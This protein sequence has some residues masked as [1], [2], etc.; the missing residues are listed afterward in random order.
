MARP[1]RLLIEDRPITVSPVLATALGINE[2]IILQQLHFLLTITEESKNR[3]N[4]IDGRWWV[5]NNYKEWKKEH[6]PWLHEGT[7]KRLFLTLEEW[8][9]VDSMQSVKNPSDRKKWYSIDYDALD[10]LEM[11][12]G[13]N[14][15][16]G[17]LEQIV[18]MVGTNCDD[19][20]SKSTSETTQR[21]QTETTLHA[22]KSNV[23]FTRA[24]RENQFPQ[25]QQSAK[26]ATKQVP[27]SSQAALFE[28][29]PSK[30]V[31]PLPSQP[32][33]PPQQRKPD[34]MYDAICL[35]WKTE[36][37]MAGKIQQQL[38]GK[39]PKKHPHSASNFA[40]PA[41]PDEVASFAKWYKNRYP[42]CDMPMSPEKI[43]HHF[44]AFRRETG[45]AA[46]KNAPKIRE[47][48]GRRLKYD[49]TL[50]SW[51]DIGPAQTPPQSPNR[52][53]NEAYAQ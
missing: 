36:G 4:F 15:D 6:F 26:R 16:D 47:Q 17:S 3:H 22:A 27:P 1:K 32:Q 44:A 9:L 52:S 31:E 28:S 33:V 10:G 11:T 30:A 14:C 49:T 51:L 12:I 34:A 8:G 43:Q 20:Y 2:A 23:D 37:G 41:T 42:G 21:V 7:I 53:Q 50:Q 29:P 18:T 48:N 38:L 19:G 46:R 25:V 35:A 13:T 24:P 45:E 40:E 39:M 5:Y